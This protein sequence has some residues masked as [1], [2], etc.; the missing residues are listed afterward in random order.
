[1]RNVIWQTLV[2]LLLTNI[3]IDV[4]NLNSGIYTNFRELLCKKCDVGY[5]VINHGVTVGYGTPFI[6]LKCTVYELWTWDRQTDRQTD[7][8]TDRSIE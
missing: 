6:A 3:I 8:R 4:T 1:M 7:R 5:Y 2:L